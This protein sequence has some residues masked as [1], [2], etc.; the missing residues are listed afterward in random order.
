MQ[1]FY[2]KYSKYIIFAIGFVVTIML[3]ASII[4]LNKVVFSTDE[5]KAILNSSTIKRVINTLLG[6]TEGIVVFATFILYL[7]E[8]DNKTNC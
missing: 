7:L 6:F 8:S 2:N 3:T 4:Y 1:G 5:F